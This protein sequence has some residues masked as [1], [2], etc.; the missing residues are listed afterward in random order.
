MAKGN[1]PK[2]E[3]KAVGARARANALTAGQRREIAEKAAAARWGERVHTAIRK[4][5]FQKEFGIDVDCY[6]L[7]DPVRTAVITQRGMGEAIGFS[8][9]GSRFTVFVGSQTMEQF[10]G[11]D[12]REKIEKPFVFQLPGAA[13]TNP[14]TERAHGYDATILIDICNS[15]LA[16]KAAG[17]LSSTRYKRMIQQAQIILSASGKSGIRGLVYALAGYN[18]SAEEVIAAFKLYVQEE[19]RKYEQEFPNELYMQW[20]RLYKI[21]VP[22]RGKPWQF[23]HLTVKHIYYPLAKSNGKILELIRALKSQDGDRQ[24]KLFQFLNDVG[25]RALRMHI[26][27]V[28]EMSESSQDK[29]TYERKVVDRF[30][31]QQELELLMPDPSTASPPPAGL[32]PPAALGS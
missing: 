27:R 16:A 6:V 18:P 14:V 29:E 20:H 15:I 30:G 17:K 21:P 11:R 7:N 9:R 23:K 2:D 5:N 8:R 28:L 25:A 4:G 32:S 22:E 13:A 26:G 24:K 1:S 3:S 10:I 31:G 19:A 12:L